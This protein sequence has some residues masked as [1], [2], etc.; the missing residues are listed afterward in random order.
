M[1]LFYITCSLWNALAYNRT[2]YNVRK[3]KIILPPF[4][5]LNVLNLKGI[6][7]Y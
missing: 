1:L 3:I 4:H 7:W 2:Y 5:F 6:G